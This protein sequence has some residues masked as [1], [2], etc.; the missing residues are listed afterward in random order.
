GMR[1]S[2]TVEMIFDNVKVPEEN[3]LGVEGEGFKQIMWQLQG[4]R[5]NG[6]ASAVGVAEH[7]YELALDY[8]KTRKA[9]EQPV[10]NFQVI[11]HL[12]AEMKTDIE[13]CKELDNACAYWYSY[14]EVEPHEILMAIL[15]Y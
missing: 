9:F 4:E 14:I 12:L 11:S 13:V 15:A 5:M 8:A 7:A 6:A 2:D 3:L 10:S 1:A